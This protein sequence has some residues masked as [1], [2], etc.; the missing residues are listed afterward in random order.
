MRIAFVM[1]V[2]WALSALFRGLLAGARSTQMLALTAVLRLATATA[3]GVAAIIL[4]TINGAV[5]GLGAWILA[6]A[7]EI[8]VLA[9]KVRRAWR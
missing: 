9:P 8:T 1:A 3:V 5:L 2:F 7:V 4:P 6:Y